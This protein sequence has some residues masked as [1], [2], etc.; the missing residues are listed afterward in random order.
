MIHC[1]LLCLDVMSHEKFAAAN[2]TGI[3][4]G[5]VGSGRSRLGKGDARTS[6]PIRRKNSLDCALMLCLGLIVKL[7]EFTLSFSLSLSLL[8]CALMLSLVLLVRLAEFICGVHRLLT[9]GR[10]G[11]VKIPCK[12]THSHVTNG[13]AKE[14]IYIYIYIYIYTHTHI[15]I[16]TYT[17]IHI[18]TYI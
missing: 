5:G 12:C 17:H 13:C 14:R 6:Q 9:S 3:W 16:Y 18:Y 4:E 1:T 8:N 11:N 15:H 2:V 7:A 10:K